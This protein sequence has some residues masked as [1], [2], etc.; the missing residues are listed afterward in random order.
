MAPEKD[1]LAAWA[2]LGPFAPKD[3]PQV[4]SK[5]PTSG[6]KTAHNDPNWSCTRPKIV[7]KWGPKTDLDDR[8]E[9][10]CLDM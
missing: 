6:L 4:A 10:P 7:R 3:G 8:R 5:R 1:P 9:E 2:R